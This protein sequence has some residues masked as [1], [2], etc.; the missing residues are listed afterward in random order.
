MSWK[1]GFT[2]REKPRRSYKG[3]EGSEENPFTPTRLLPLRVPRKERATILLPLSK[4][5]PIMRTLIPLILLL[6]TQAPL[7]WGLT[8]SLVTTLDSKVIPLMHLLLHLV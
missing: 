3:H 1:Q 5:M 2:R 4:D 7:K 6:L 8:L